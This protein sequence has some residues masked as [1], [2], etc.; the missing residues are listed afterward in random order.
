MEPNIR[1]RD[2]PLG[3]VLRLRAGGGVTL[4][5]ATGLAF[6]RR[7]RLYDGATKMLDYDLKD[8]MFTRI[9]IRAGGGTMGKGGG[10]SGG[11]GRGRG[12]GGD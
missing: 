11:G 10:R 5:I 8:T 12:R 7:Y 4:E 1:Y 3:P 9:G 6:A 2:M